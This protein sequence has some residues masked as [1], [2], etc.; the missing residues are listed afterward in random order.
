MCLQF[1]IILLSGGEAPTSLHNLN[2]ASSQYL[3]I[4]QCDYST[5]YDYSCTDGYI[6]V[7]C[8]KFTVQSS[9]LK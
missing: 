6:S 1:F 5:Y 3:N 2:C 7:I 8:C 9:N 4:F